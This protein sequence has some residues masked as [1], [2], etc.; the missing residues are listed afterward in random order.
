MHD[1]DGEPEIRS[2]PRAS[3]ATAGERGRPLHER[4][5]A[6]AM[7]EGEWVGWRDVAIDLATGTLVAG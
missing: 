1:R 4:G 2:S 7:C 5:L 3:S 6:A